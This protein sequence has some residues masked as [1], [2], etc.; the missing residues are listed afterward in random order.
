ME[1]V[2]F[3]QSVAQEYESTF[4]LDE[5]QTLV[6]KFFK[7]DEDELAEMKA[8]RRPGRPASARQDLLQAKLNLGHKEYNS[9]FWLP[10]MEDERNVERLQEWNG[11]WESLN[12]LT[13]IRITRAGSKAPSQF[14]PNREN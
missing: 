6:E 14:P 5:M 4:T 1:R 13:F 11:E 7:Q 12:N 3:F 8:K 10:D 2:A 9:G